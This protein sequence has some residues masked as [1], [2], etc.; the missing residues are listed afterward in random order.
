MFIATC[1]LLLAGVLSAPN[2][3]SRLAGVVR[4]AKDQP[5]AGA[6]LEARRTEHGALTAKDFEGAPAKS[7]R[8]DA[9]G[10]WALPGLD[11][12]TWIV[13][14]VASTTPRT[15]DEMQQL[16]RPVSGGAAPEG[17]A[18]SR[19]VRQFGTAS[20]GNTERLDIGLPLGCTTATPLH[21]RITGVF[22]PDR[23]AYEVRVT[24]TGPIHTQ[25]G[26]GTVAITFDS[27][28]KQAQPA[29]SVVPDAD[30]RFDFGSLDV[31][32]HDL[33]EV[34]S[35]TLDLEDSPGIS[36]QFS[37]ILIGFE[38]WQDGVEIPIL[39]QRTVTLRAFEPDG[40]TLL[41][42][43]G[44]EA[45]S[46][47]VWDGAGGSTEWDGDAA[48]IERPLKLGTYLVQAS[49]GRGASAITAFTLDAVGP[50][51]VALVLKTC[52]DFTVHLVDQHGAPFASTSLKLGVEA[53]AAFPQPC[54]IGA[55]CENGVVELSHVLPGT[56]QVQIG[57]GFRKPAS[58]VSL[59]LK[60]GDE[61][62]VVNVP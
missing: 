61:P 3:E 62:I 53:S 54:R 52:P 10:R 9:E 58:I 21:G 41:D 23:F 2:A 16:A 38:H 27:S 57:N 40:T 26:E 8:S 49:Q 30:G 36:A 18:L 50:A 22:A 47:S 55:F 31:S 7:A 35:F 33:I 14:A 39:S 42:L 24:R 32:P 1:A 48:E 46:F 51:E 19:L 12:G 45:L 44:N 25:A 4:D 5:I 29:Y 56:Y 20:K 37:G 17:V 60:P 11:D 13:T 6:W 28:Y 43:G 15:D 59:D 34:A